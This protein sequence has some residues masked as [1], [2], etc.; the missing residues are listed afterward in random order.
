MALLVLVVVVADGFAAWAF[1]AQALVDAF[2]QLFFAIVAANFFVHGAGITDNR[3]ACTGGR[4]F[5]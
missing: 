1:D 3:P 2:G 5:G 4:V